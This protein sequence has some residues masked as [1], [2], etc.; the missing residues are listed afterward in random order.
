VNIFRVVTITVAFIFSFFNPFGDI[1]TM[2]IFLIYVEDSQLY[3]FNLEHKQ[4]CLGH[5]NVSNKN[6][7]FSIL[8]IFVYYICFGRYAIFNL[9]LFLELH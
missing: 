4:W 3:L 5:N 7:R 8:S 2:M 6:Q 9:F 1:Y